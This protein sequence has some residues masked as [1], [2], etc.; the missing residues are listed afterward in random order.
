M[1]EICATVLYS[2][3]KHPVLKFDDMKKNPSI[4]QEVY[5]K[6]ADNFIALKKD[7]HDFCE[8]YIRPVQQKNWDWS[9]RDFS[10]PKN[11]PTLAEAKAIRRVIYKDMMRSA[12]T[13]VD[14]T[15]MK[16]L[17][18]IRSYLKPS[19]KYEE[20]NMKDFAYALN[21]EL[22]HGRLN[23]VNVTSNHPFLTAMIALAHLTETTT[24]YKRLKIMET[25]GAMFEITRKIKQTRTNKAKW[26]KELFEKQEELAEARK[27][28]S[29]MM[30][31]LAS[32]T[33]PKEIGD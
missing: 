32:V 30:E 8:K 21:V 2:G 33:P 31:Q 24:Y 4:Y 9:K 22:E 27:E 13:E 25:E 12:R 15:T 17:E 10:I 6:R 23:Q 28:L 11:K 20:A 1:W 14:L 3:R 18:A 16:N 19:P 26:F 7:V 5:I 29:E